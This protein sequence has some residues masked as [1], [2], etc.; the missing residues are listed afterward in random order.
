MM[1][2]ENGKSTVT[3]NFLARIKRVRAVYISYIEVNFHIR[4]SRSSLSKHYLAGF[5]KGMFISNTGCKQIHIP[6]KMWV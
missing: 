6:K 4:N 3:T 1:S 2:F 5:L